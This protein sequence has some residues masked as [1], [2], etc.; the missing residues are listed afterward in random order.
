M[1]MQTI[2]S[3]IIAGSSEQAMFRGDDGE[4]YFLDRVDA[5]PRL[6]DGHDST[7]I[8]LAIETCDAVPDGVPITLEQLRTKLRGEFAFTGILRRLLVGMDPDFSED[9]RRRSICNANRSLDSHPDIREKV[10]QR[11]LRSA[12]L[13]EWNPA[14]AAALAE[15]FNASFAQDIYLKVSAIS[16]S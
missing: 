2:V 10:E 4:L 9:L 14:A 8:K 16:V 11:I 3:G 1:P 5:E 7:S 12:D 6:A 13:R 15:K